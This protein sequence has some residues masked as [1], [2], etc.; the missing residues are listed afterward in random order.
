MQLEEKLER[1]CGFLAVVAR[2]ATPLQLTLPVLYP[3][4]ELG[5]ATLNR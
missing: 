5:A 2:L 3:A 4:A 1:F